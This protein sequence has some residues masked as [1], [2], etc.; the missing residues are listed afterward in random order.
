MASCILGLMLYHRA[1]SQHTTKTFFSYFLSLFKWYLLITIIITV[2]VCAGTC[3]SWMESSKDFWE[4][5]SFHLVFEAGPLLCVFVCVCVCMCAHA[6]VS[7]CTL[8]LL[9]ASGK[10]AEGFSGKLAKGFSCFC[11]PSYSV[12]SGIT[13]IPHHFDVLCG[14]W[15]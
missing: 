10:L 4:L 1:T 11:L 9:H 3:V 2:Y 8:L 14:F 6:S 5:G 7:L 15:D 12:S 13:D